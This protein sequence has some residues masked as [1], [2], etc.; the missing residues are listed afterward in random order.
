MPI[1]KNKV[2][3]AKPVLCKADRTIAEYRQWVRQFYSHPA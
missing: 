1:W 3:R 2:H